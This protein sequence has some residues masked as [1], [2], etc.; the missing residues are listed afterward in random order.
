MTWLVDEL[1]KIVFSSFYD[2]V[3]KRKKLVNNK[4]KN[5]STKESQFLIGQYIK[6]KL[7]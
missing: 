4:I 1:I 7:L 2:A 5:I 3:N 6:M